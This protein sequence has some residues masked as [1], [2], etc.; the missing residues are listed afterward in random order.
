MTDYRAR[1]HFGWDF[2]NEKKLPTDVRWAGI[3]GVWPI[4]EEN[5]RHATVMNSFFMPAMEGY[6]D[7]SLIRRVTGYRLD[8][9]SKRYWIQ[10]RSLEDDKERA[11]ILPI[12]EKWEHAW[13]NVPKDS[14]TGTSEA[15]FSLQA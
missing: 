15:T 3:E 1:D 7:G 12:K 5:L 2:S 13:L 14:G 6:V 9:A 10:T 11:L 8:L 4:S